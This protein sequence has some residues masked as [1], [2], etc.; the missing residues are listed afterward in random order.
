MQ[1]TPAPEAKPVQEEKIDIAVVPKV[2]DIPY[3]QA[4]REGVEEAAK[5]SGA[6][7][8]FKWQI[9]LSKK[10]SLIH[11]KNKRSMSWQSA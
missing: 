5:S 3:F 1:E 4:V 8:H 7:I 2:M 10:K 11:S 6:I 9:Q